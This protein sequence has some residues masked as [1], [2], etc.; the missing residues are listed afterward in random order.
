MGTFLKVFAGVWVVV[1]TAG[2]TSNPVVG[3]WRYSDGN[4]VIDLSVQDKEACE[5]SLSRFVNKDLKRACRYEL[6]KMKVKA[7]DSP[8]QSY[9]V[10]LHDDAG[11]CDAFA[12]FEFTHDVNSGLLTF[13]VGD[14]P[15]YMQQQK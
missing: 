8:V 1:I 12:D 7:A 5:L 6:N 2:C 3:D 13:L 11:R 15:F 4:T 10:Y 9:L 14:T